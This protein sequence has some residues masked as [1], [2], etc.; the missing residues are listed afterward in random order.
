MKKEGPKTIEAQVGNFMMVII[1]GLSMENFCPNE[2]AKI[3]NKI[4]RCQKYFIL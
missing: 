1:A 2:T 4:Y 3:K